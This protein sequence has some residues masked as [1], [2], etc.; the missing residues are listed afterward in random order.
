MAASP[1]LTKPLSLAKVGYLTGTSGKN[2]PLKLKKK[3]KIVQNRYMSGNFSQH[4]CL[5]A[6]FLPLNCLEIKPVLALLLS[7]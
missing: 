2:F 3:K 7:S 6:H 5:L 1:S 4:P